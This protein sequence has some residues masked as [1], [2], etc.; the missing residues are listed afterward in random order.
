MSSSLS[1]IFAVRS[2]FRDINGINNPEWENSS[3]NRSRANL[4][5][6]KTGT[7]QLFDRLGKET[8]PDVNGVAWSDIVYFHILGP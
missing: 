5:L 3:I 7:V 4:T 2:S 6:A 1:A 8:V